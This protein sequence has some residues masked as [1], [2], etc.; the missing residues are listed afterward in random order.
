M[1]GNHAQTCRSAVHC[2]KL[3]IVRKRFHNVV[4]IKFYSNSNG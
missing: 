2:V 3:G 1:F 4:F